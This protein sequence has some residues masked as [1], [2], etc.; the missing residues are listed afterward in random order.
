MAVLGPPMLTQEQAVEVRVLKRQ[1]KSIRAIARELGLSRVTVRRYL[2]KS[3]AQRYGPRALISQSTTTVSPSQ[4]AARL[5]RPLQ[6]PL[7]LLAPIASTSSPRKTS[8]PRQ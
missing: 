3:G 2:R 5:R 6:R 1:G 7:Q 4:D 8:S